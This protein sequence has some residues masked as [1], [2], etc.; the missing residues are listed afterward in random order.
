MVICSGE[1]GERRLKGTTGVGWEVSESCNLLLITMDRSS[2]LIELLII[3]RLVDLPEAKV[4]KALQDI[5]DSSTAPPQP[6]TL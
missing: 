6:S 1:L 4:R 3:V 2:R 5:P